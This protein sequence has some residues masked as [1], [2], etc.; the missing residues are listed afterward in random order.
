MGASEKPDKSARL[1]DI[2]FLS[3]VFVVLLLW[4]LNTPPGLLGK[5]DATAYAVCHRIDARS[6]HIGD[7]PLPLCIRCSGMY[8]GVVL[9]LVFLSTAYPRRGGIPRPGVLVVLGLLFLAWAFDGVNSF[10]NL[11]PALPSLYPSHHFLRLTTGMGMGIVLAVMVYVGFNQTVW[12]F[13]DNRPLLHNWKNQLALAL[14]AAALIALVWIQNPVVLYP[15]AFVSTAGIWIILTMVYT[16]IWLMITR[17]ENKYTTFRELTVPL[18]AGFGLA[19][20]QVSFFNLVRFFLTGT[21]AGF[22]FG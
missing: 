1:R 12:T 18:I 7:R 10:L 4:L 11:I 3:V 15:L 16:L 2:I 14:A 8:L 22:S 6:F 9:G 5:A 13:L 17:K 20:L 19:L 21:W